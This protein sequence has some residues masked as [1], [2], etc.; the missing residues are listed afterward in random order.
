MSVWRSRCWCV[1]V[2]VDTLFGYGRFVCS[3]H[4]NSIHIFYQIHFN[5]ADTIRTNCDTSAFKSHDTVESQLTHTNVSNLGGYIVCKVWLGAASGSRNM[6]LH[7]EDLPRHRQT[8]TW[9]C[10]MLYSQTFGDNFNQIF[11]AMQVLID[12]AQVHCCGPRLKH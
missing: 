7:D 4:T 3:E 5:P 9:R 2:C 11:W 8:Q 10:W 1:W 6:T 12:A